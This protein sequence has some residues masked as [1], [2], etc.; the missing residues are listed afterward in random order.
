MYEVFTRS[1]EIRPDV[2]REQFQATLRGGLE[3][4]QRQNFAMQV[5]RYIATQFFRKLFQRL[6]QKGEMFFLYYCVYMLEIFSQ[7]PVFLFAA[8]LDLL[9]IM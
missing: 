4:R 7:F 6:E 8:S 5:H 9:A 2:Q 1:A 3:Y